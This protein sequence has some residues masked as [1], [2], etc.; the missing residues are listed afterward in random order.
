MGP[1]SILTVGGYEFRACAF[2]AKLTRS[3]QFCR[4]GA[5][6]NDESCAT[7]PSGI[8]HADVSDYGRSAALF[9]QVLFSSHLL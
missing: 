8:A 4:D 1:E 5:S 7:G 9:R 6:G 2:S 3:R